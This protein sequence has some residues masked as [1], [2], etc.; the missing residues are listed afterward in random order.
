MPTITIRNVPTDVHSTLVARAA[1][2]GI[3]LQTYLLGELVGLC[4]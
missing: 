2:K 3:S 1:L 4:E